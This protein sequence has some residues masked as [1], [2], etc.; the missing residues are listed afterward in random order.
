MSTSRKN[1][2]KPQQ[3]TLA[4]LST[5]R[6]NQMKFGGIMANTQHKTLESAI[7]EASKEEQRIAKNNTTYSNGAQNIPYNAHSNTNNTQ[8]AQTDTPR[9]E[10]TFEI[11]C[12]FSDEYRKIRATSFVQAISSACAEFHEND[13]DFEVKDVVFIRLETNPVFVMHSV[14]GNGFVTRLRCKID[15][16]SVRPFWENR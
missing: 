3:K 13:S 4:A 7:N 8:N 14:A 1:G 16:D 9:I 11:Y 5:L 15:K 6:K 12:P 10:N 2:K